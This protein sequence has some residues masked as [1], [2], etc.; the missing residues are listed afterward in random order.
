MWTGVA[1]DIA[2]L[3]ALM[4]SVGWFVDRSNAIDRCSQALA[5]GV[6]CTN[7]PKLASERDLSIGGLAVSTVGLAAGA[8]VTGLAVRKMRERPGVRVAGGCAP[9]AG[10]LTCTVGGTW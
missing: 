10:G 1:L 2:F 6:D 4:G 8:I 7:G 9:G 5:Q 3:G